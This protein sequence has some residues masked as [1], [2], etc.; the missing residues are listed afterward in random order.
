VTAA[1]RGRPGIRRCCGLLVLALVLLVIP[2]AS[3]SATQLSLVKLQ[4]AK[5]VD[6]GDGVVWVLVLGSDARDGTDVMK[7]NADAIQLV[8]VNF[9]TG[10]AIALGV[11]RDSW[12]D[13]PGYGFNRINRGLPL[14][15][16]DLMARLVRN[17]IGIAPQY[18]ATTGFDGF[19]S[20]VDAIGGIVVRSDRKFDDSEFGLSIHVGRNPMTGAVATGYARSRYEFPRGD[21]E[22]S[23][24]HQALLKAILEKVRRQEDVEG[25]IEKG[26]VA[27]LRGLETNLGPGELYHFAQALTQIDLK[28]VT[29][30]VIDGE[31]RT[32]A[33]GASVVDPDFAQAR[34]L[35]IDARDDASLER[36][37]RG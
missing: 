19:G 30:C 1:Y 28:R 4:T 16:P 36:G 20:M 2:D 11:P 34:R 26:A 10:S 3:R 31:P 12:V 33:G 8:G 23:A 14:D 37:C 7:G 15:G 17:L 25:F 5:A 35:G 21:F 13:I 32:T 6:F 22:R 18:V 9:E 24:N 27:A 29:L